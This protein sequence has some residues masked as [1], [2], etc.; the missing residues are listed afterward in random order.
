MKPTTIAL[1]AL[2]LVAL[3]V[4]IILMRQPGEVST[5]GSTGMTIAEFDSASI[6]RIE[7]RGRSES[8]VL[9]K[10]PDGWMLVSPM[11]Y[12]ADGEAVTQA[13][14]KARRTNVMSVVSTNPAKQSLFQVDTTGTL[15][16]F[17]AQG[18]IRTAFRVGKTS[19]SY[20]ETY[21]RRENS[22]DVLLADGVLISFYSKTPGDWRD[23]TIFSTPEE[24]V[25]SVQLRFGDTTFTLSRSDSAWTLDG[26]PAQPAMVRSFLSSLAHFQAD[27]FVDTAVSPMPPQT[28]TISV[29]ETQ[30][31][32]FRNAGATQ[33][34]VAASRGPQLF[35]VSSWKA[36]QLLKRKR[37]FLGQK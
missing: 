22:T 17:S 32:F 28:C 20:T 7:V 3:V 24:T 15:V 10:Q 21:V 1:L 36:D 25:T 12:R 5:S 18:E 31:S 23:R 30:I 16:S 27:S 19:P 8:A 37:E 34:Y 29:Q 35:S 26:Q 33:Y 11:R 13:L 9:E 2:L 4:A 6:D 14:S